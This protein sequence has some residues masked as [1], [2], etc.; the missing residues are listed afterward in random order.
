MMLG[1]RD[2]GWQLATEDKKQDMK[3]KKVKEKQKNVSDAREKGWKGTEG[4]V[5]AALDKTQYRL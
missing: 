2:A 1:G 3:D 5:P 4:E